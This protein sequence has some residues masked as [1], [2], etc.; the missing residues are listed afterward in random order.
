MQLIPW[1]VL[2]FL[3]A[4]RA[5]TPVTIY[6][7]INDQHSGALRIG[8][9]AALRKA[10]V[11]IGGHGI[12]QLSGA[13]QNSISSKQLPLADDPAANSLR[14]NDAN[15]ETIPSPPPLYFCLYGIS[16]DCYTF[17]Y[18]EGSYVA[19]R[20]LSDSVVLAREACLD[21]DLNRG[22]TDVQR[23]EV[24]GI[25]SCADR[26]VEKSA[27]LISGTPDYASNRW[28][29][30]D[31]PAPSPAV[32]PPAPAMY[33]CHDGLDGNCYSY[34]Y[35]EGSYI[36]ANYPEDTLENARLACHRQ[37]NNQDLTDLM[38]DEIFGNGTCTTEDFESASRAQSVPAVPGLPN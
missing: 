30:L 6:S 4:T 37:P 23:D 26:P 12:L 8:S 32:L 25:G 16:G 18:G 27:S 35:G 21:Q 5:L 11:S 34:S 17:S 38:M 1:H 33:H 15:N 36:V 13:M 29:S 2:Y 28:R 10:E 7:A 31:G 3:V 22:L 24:F 20:Y 14:L 19:P 9:R